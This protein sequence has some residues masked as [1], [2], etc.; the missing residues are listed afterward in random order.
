MSPD[1]KHLN[2]YIKKYMLYDI[3]KKLKQL[4]LIF[5]IQ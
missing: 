5:L 2:E 1:E 3:S 4:K